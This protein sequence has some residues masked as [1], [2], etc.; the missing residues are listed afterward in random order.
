[1]SARFR[2][3]LSALSSAILA[4]SLAPAAPLATAATD[5]AAALQGSARITGTVETAERGE[6]LRGAI[7]RIESLNLSTVT[8]GEG[9][10]T[11]RRLSPGTYTVQVSYIDRE[12]FATTVEILGDETEELN[13]ALLR[14]GQTAGIEEVVVV[15]RLIADAEAAAL[16]RQRAADSVK[17]ILASDSIGR[18]PDQNA[19]DALGRV[20]GISIER[21]QGQARFVNVRGAPAQFTNIAFNGVAAPTPSS[22][23]RQTR[24]DTVSNHIIKSIEIQKAVTPDVPA[25]SIGGFINVE[26]NGA[27]DKEGFYADVAAAGGIRELGGGPIEQYQFTASNTWGE[28]R[29]GGDRFGVLVSASYYN[30]NQVTDNTENRFSVQDD[31][32]IWSDQADYRIYRLNRSNTSLN[33]RLDFRPSENHSFYANFIYSDF[34]DFEIRDQHVY[35]FDDSWFGHPES[36][37]DTPFD[38]ATSNPVRG[39]I[40][41]VGVDTTSNVRTDVEAVFATQFGGE[42]NLST[43]HV[44]W[45]GGFNNSE[46]SRDSDNAYF[47]HDIPAFRENNPDRPGVSV[48]YDYTDP[49]KPITQ[50]FNTVVNPDTTVPDAERL[51]LGQRL[52]GPPTD[53]FVFDNVE[54]EFEEG[55]VDEIFFQF[56]VERPWAPFGITSDLQFGGRY[57]NRNATLDAR[58]FTQEDID[59]PFRDI[60]SGR[61]SRATFPQPLMNEFDDSAAVALRASSLAEATAQGVFLNASDV[62]EQFY[63]VDEIVTA[64]YAMN[65]FR[66]DKFDIIVGARVEYTDMS[67]IGNQP[68]DEDAIDDILEGANAPV[69]LGD[70]LSARDENGDPILGQVNAEQDYVDVFPALH[71]NYR[72][73]EDL[74]VR[75]AYTETILRPSYSEFAPNRVVGEDSDEQAG[76]IFISGGNPELEPYRAQNFDLYVERYLPYRGILSF[77]LFAKNIDDPIFNAQ[78]EVDGGAF[79]FPGGRVRLSGPLNGSDG[80]IRGFEATYS[81]QFGFLPSPFDGFGVQL[82]YTYAEDDARTPPLFNPETGLND[83]LS[84]STGLSGASDQTYN[85]SV[86]FEKYGVSARLSYQYRSEWLNAID[87]QEERL[88]RFW[89]ERPSVDFSFRYSISD[90]WLLFLDANNLTDE[91]GRRFNGNTNNV[92]EVEGFGRSYL[93]GVRASI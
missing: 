81:Q 80:E 44:E 61:P 6:R 53:F 39:T 60:L 13:I 49:D 87:L 64:V 78:Q 7:V 68:F 84:R 34:Q 77:G 55:L 37:A 69:A 82:N 23:G 40:F 90:N 72:P 74:V 38:P 89:D 71:I 36:D 92:Y 33:T 75:F 51:A 76:L 52:A 12:P 91:F 54:Q 57:S 29:D 10:F 83:G 88:D 32:Q 9:S 19:A 48:T 67:G 30:V 14:R 26:T 16:S 35:D 3:R 27:F 93:F 21:D 31:G 22:G 4:A 41:G 11:L 70:L 43:W 47:D 46:S 59:V 65:T 50:V 20:P 17:N 73:M 86:F 8:D 85:A 42:H 15:G 2:P 25:D 56:D 24:F 5:P 58:V 45:V 1:M 63:D 28:N 62:W 79:G 18:F 66:W